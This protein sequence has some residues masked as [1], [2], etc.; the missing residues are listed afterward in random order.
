VIQ[1]TRVDIDP[2][3][4]V[5]MVADLRDAAVGWA[6]IVKV[7]GSFNQWGFELG[8]APSD[9]VDLNRA[10]RVLSYGLS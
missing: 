1:L 7:G 3:H 10:S 5:R 8:A 6:D 4:D 2:V 9:P